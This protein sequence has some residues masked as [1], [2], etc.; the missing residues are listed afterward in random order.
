MQEKIEITQKDFDLIQKN[1]H[2]DYKIVISGSEHLHLW[3]DRKHFKKLIQRST[4]KELMFI[5]LEEF[6]FGSHKPPVCAPESD[7]FISDTNIAV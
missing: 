6:S 5:I 7:F 1:K 2:P 3:H 4:S